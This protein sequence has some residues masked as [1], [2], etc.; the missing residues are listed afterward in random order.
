MAGGHLAP[1]VRE[2]LNLVAD[3][4]ISV[5]RRVQRG[6]TN[7]SPVS[8]FGAVDVLLWTLSYG[9]SFLIRFDGTIPREYLA[10]M[11][12]VLMLFI[13]VKLVWHMGFRLYR[14]TWDLVGLMEVV[15]AWKASTCAMLTLA[16]AL[17]LLQE[18]W[19]VGTFPRSVFI[20]DY[21]L[22]GCFI[23]I[24]R[25]GQRLLNEVF[26]LRLR[27]AGGTRVLLVGAGAAGQL[28]VRSMRNARQVEYQPVAFIDD[29]PAKR[30]RYVHGLKV[31]GGK[32][33]IPVAVRKY[34]VEEVLITIVSTG[35]AQVRDVIR[36][37]REAGIKR[38]RVLPSINEL[39]AGG[40]TVKDLREVHVE[41]LLGRE[42]LHLDG[43][44][45]NALL[46]GQTVLVTGASGSIGGELVRQLARSE[47]GHLVLL[48]MDETGLFH[49]ESEIRDQ[50]PARQVHTLIADIRDAEKMHRVFTAWRPSVVY[51]AAAY[52]H[53]PLMET[54]PDEAV[55]TN[56]IGTLIVAEAALAVETETFVL[57]STDK[58]AHATSVMGATKRVAELLM[59]ALNARGGTRFIAVRFG[60]VLGSRGSVIPVMQEQI[61]RGGPVTITHPEMTRYFMSTREAVALVLQASAAGESHDIFML[62]MGQPI[63]IVDLATELI[64]LSGL[65]PDRDIPIV[66]TGIRPGERLH[67]A[68]STPDE[69]LERTALPG[70]FAVRAPEQSD[71]VMLRLAI[72]ELD[73]M[74]Q[75]MDLTGV[76]HMLQQL[77]VAPERLVAAPGRLPSWAAGARTPSSPLA[78]PAAIQRAADVPVTGG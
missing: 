77:V 65:D 72:R 50:C 2:G 23:A 11:P 75:A 41:D 59:K 27:K 42:P 39:L 35:A 58:A 15:A 67:E 47:A 31:L 74:S 8:L 73:R 19:A 10:A 53:V 6:A 22:S 51:H 70:V 40:V 71:E 4:A 78:I 61:R 76:R 56:I 49:L 5:L 16:G 45:V 66:F 34:G 9:L 68:L 17:F 30:G 25:L 14:V 37:A 33:A 21:V 62:D 7:T 43:R 18:I 12:F 20:F 32:E 46:K 24:S 69:I 26:F 29:D 60:N 36:Y 55:R 63:K 52:K 3:R 38:V 1:D 54:H 13:P 28:I 44:R 57:I 48:D 64:R